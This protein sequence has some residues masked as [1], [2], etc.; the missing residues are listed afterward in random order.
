MSLAYQVFDHKPKYWVNFI[1]TTTVNLVMVLQEELNCSLMLCIH[2]VGYMVDEQG[3][4][5]TNMSL[6]S[7]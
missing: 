2:H 3:R 1:S 4:R 7:S 5:V 6:D